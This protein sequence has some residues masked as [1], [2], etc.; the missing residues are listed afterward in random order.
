VTPREKWEQAKRRAQEVNTGPVM[1]AMV[2]ALEAKQ[3]VLK[4]TMVDATDEEMPKLARAV[5][6]LRA[7]VKDLSKPPAPT[8]EHKTGDY[9]GTARPGGED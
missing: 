3:E 2:N 9:S 1:Q 5:R 6:E 8:R 4:E 7:V